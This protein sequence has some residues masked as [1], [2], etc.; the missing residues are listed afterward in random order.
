LYFDVPKQLPI[1][2]ST[3]L[4]QSVA[5]ATQSAGIGLIVGV[6][7]AQV[8]AKKVITTMWLYFCAL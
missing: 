8:V 7:S 5:S 3:A 4:L 2:K 6:L 1:S